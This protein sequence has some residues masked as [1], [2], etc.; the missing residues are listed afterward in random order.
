MYNLLVLA[1]NN[2]II[3]QWGYANNNSNT[4]GIKYNNFPI[5]FTNLF[6]ITI[7]PYEATT[8]TFSSTQVLN[9]LQ[10]FFTSFTVTAMNNV[11]WGSQRRYY[12]FYISIGI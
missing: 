9:A 12:T 3:L 4:P 5:S 11:Q 6:A 1:F 2:S 10:W 8:S 7:T